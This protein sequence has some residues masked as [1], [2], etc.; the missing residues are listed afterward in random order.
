VVHLA[1]GNLG[2]EL[3]DPAVDGAAIAHRIEVDGLTIAKWEVKRSVGTMGKN[4][5]PVAIILIVLLIAVTGFT[6]KS[7]LHLQDGIY[8]LGTND[9]ELASIF[10]GDARFSVDLADAGAI[11]SNQDYYDLI[12]LNRMVYVHDTDRGKAAAKTLDR[13]YTKYR[14]NV[15]NQQSDLFAAYPLWIDL[16]YVT[17]ELNFTATQS[18][19]QVSLRPRSGQPPVPTG[20]VEPVATPEA[21]IGISSEDLRSNLQQSPSQNSQIS[22]YTDMFSGSGN[23]LGEYK[24]PDQL[25]PSLPFDSIILVFL[26]IFPLYFMS[27]FYMMSIM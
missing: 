23:P 25:S 16:Q 6:A 9:P 7:G 3:T 13:D 5:L 11:Q 18:G 15:Y 26:F 27:Q 19:Q 17:S 4:V 10:S 1:V 12:I 8:K 2:H 14:S 21:S 24:T 22:R 20:P